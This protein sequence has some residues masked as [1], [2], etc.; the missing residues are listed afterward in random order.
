MVT[1]NQHG[2]RRDGSP[3]SAETR[4][5]MLAVL[6]D[7]YG[8]ADVLHVGQAPRPEIGDDEIL[9][10][11]R[12]AGVHIGDWHLMTGLPYLMRVMGFGFRAP[13]A[14]IRGSD[15]A[16]VVVAVGSEVTRFR[17]GDEVFGT[18]KGSF[19]EF[20]TTPADRLVL[21]PSNLT[22]EQAAGLATSGCTALHAFRAA[23]PATTKERVLIIGA[24]GSVGIYAVQ[25]AKARGAHVTGVCS[26]AKMDLVRAIGADHVVDYTRENI[27]DVA[28]PYDLV[29]DMAGNRSL[30]LLRRATAPHGTVVIVGGEAGGRVT[31]GIGRSLRAVVLSRFV[32]QKL[33]V[34]SAVVNADDLSTLQ[35]LTANNKIKPVVD[36]TFA[37]SEVA[38]A[39][40][41]L[42]SG[43]A[44]GKII[45]V[46][47]QRALS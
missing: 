10:H 13:K 30:S 45:I 39:L 6:Q 5:T 41:H 32:G 46:M 20:A 3:R 12:A 44:R 2:S 9:V 27:A 31:G 24:S 11:V 8:S 4:E 26:T 19:A 34:V 7:K 1:E 18:C 25:I 43:H 35:D 36:K 40:Q 22:F 37:F 28:Q 15:V 29:L 38:D 17:A 16:G 33:R 21:K 47:P 42:R 23:G 14:R